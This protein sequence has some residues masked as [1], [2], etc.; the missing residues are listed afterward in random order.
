MENGIRRWQSLG[1]VFLFFV[2]CAVMLASTAP[3]ARQF[4]GV[5]P[6]LFIGIVTSLGTMALTAVFTRWEGLR[7]E[8][9]GAAISKRSPVRLAIGFVLGLLLVALHMSIVALA[10][11]VRWVRAEGVGFLN[12]VTSLIIYLLLSCR[13]ELAFRG[14]PLRRLNPVF[15]LWA[16]QFIVS[17]VFALEHIAGGSTWLQALFGAGVGSLLFGMASIA[18]KGLAVPIGLHAAWNFGDWLHG[19]KGSGGLWHPIGAEALRDRAE[20]AGMTG[21]VVVMISATLGFWWFYRRPS[22]DLMPPT[23]GE[24]R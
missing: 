2:F 8:D 21:Y 9:V 24:D 13:E 14:Y 15:G 12:I 17:L 10:A 1:R 11:N 4:T 18:T 19:G 5:P 3:V 22:R 23:R 6:G 16:S 7:L 20:L